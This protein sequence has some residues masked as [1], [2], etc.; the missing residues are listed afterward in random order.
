MTLHVSGKLSLVLVPA[1]IG[2][3]L[4]VLELMLT[5]VQCKYRGGKGQLEAYV[6]LGPARTSK[7]PSGDLS[8]ESGLG[9][10]WVVWVSGSAR[11][12]PHMRAV[13]PHGGLREIANSEKHP[14]LQMD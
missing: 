2:A 3:G 6:A 11:C 13:G 7:P 1:N 10:V 8:C 4:P 14:S 9:I 12:V 5:S